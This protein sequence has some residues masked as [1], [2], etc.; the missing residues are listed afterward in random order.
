MKF[1]E[2]SI[3]PPDVRRVRIRE[4]DPDSP[5]AVVLKYLFHTPYHSED[6]FSWGDS[7]GGAADLAMALCAE[8][9]G[10]SQHPRIY[11]FVKQEMIA[12]LDPELGW[13]IPWTRVLDSISRAGGRAGDFEP[14]PVRGD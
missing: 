4:G 8:V 10:G 12:P 7:D 2:G 14:E 6:G 13:E 5:Y 11:Q 3:L 1:F 9:M